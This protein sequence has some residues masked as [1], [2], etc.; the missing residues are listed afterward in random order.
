[1]FDYPLPMLPLPRAL[2][3]QQGSTPPFFLPYIYV[4]SADASYVKLVTPWGEL[5]A[6]KRQ[7]VLSALAVV[8]IV[9]SAWAVRLF[10]NRQYRQA[11]SLTRDPRNRSQ[12]KEA[13]QARSALQENIIKK[14]ENS[15]YYAHQPRGDQLTKEELKKTMVSSYGWTDNKKTVSIYLTDDA[16]VDMKDEQLQLEWTATSL[17]MDLVTDADAKLAKSL[18]IPT[19]F[20]RVSDVQWKV[21]KNQL[22]VTLTKV[23]AT[24]WTSLNGA[25][26]NLEEH[27][28]Y[29]ESLYD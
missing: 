18:V 24:P 17:T 10:Q 4:P 26:K 27:I 22:T 21:K 5:H 14:G 16:V 6:E 12:T 2:M 7:L 11:S 1:M 3:P 8:V 15:Y 28:E 13:Q 29:D 25:A 20:G 23:D 9:A 19:L